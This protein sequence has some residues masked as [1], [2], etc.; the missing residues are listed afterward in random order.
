MKAALD[1]RWRELEQDLGSAMQQCEAQAAT[2]IQ[3]AEFLC[4]ATIE[5]A[6]AH[7]VATIREMEDHSTA[8]VHALQ[9]SH[10]EGILN[11]EGKALER[12]ECAC[13]TLLEACGAALRACPKE[14]YGILLYP[15][16]LLMGNILLASPLTAIPQPAPLGR[17]PQFTIPPLASKLPSFPTGTKRWCHPSGKEATGLAPLTKEPTCQKQKKGRPSWG[18]KKIARRPFVRTWI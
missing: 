12:E 10:R 1:S 6:E 18:S 8:Q 7:F 5:E 16:Q 17:E 3:E 9:Q 15:L 11:F 13:L 2:A 14:A 4:V